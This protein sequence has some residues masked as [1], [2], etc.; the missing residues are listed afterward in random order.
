MARLVLTDASPLVGLS[1]VGG[2][3]W[4]EEL[5]GSVEMTR[6]VRAELEK[7]GLEP[8]IS[9]GIDQGWLR[10]RAS[11]PTLAERPPHLGEEEWSTIVAGREHAGPVLLLLD[12]RL[13]RREARTAG[14]SFAGTAGSGRERAHSP[15][16][17]SSNTS[18]RTTRRT[19]GAMRKS[20]RRSFWNTSRAEATIPRR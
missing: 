14:L 16:S 18:S 4:L 7:S 10:T 17:P 1:R 8:G 13:A 2:V 11:D 5:F 15:L 12:D 6:A 3:V 20:E 9:A 19:S